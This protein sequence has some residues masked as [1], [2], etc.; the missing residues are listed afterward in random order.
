MLLTFLTQAYGADT[1][2]TV[3][4]TDILDVAENNDGALHRLYDKTYKS[5]YG[6]ALSIT[7]DPHDA[8]DT[9]QEVFVA[10]MKSSHTYSPKGKPMAWILTLTK[11]LSFSKLRKRKNDLSLEESLNQNE[12]AFADID[13]I[14]TKMIVKSLMQTLSDE[15]RQIV[16]LKVLS[17]LKSREIG[18]ILGIPLNTVLSKYSRALKKLKNQ[19]E[20]GTK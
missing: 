9:V 18:Q 19:L 14:E 4:D 3:N 8:E 2:C 7:K 6:F 17:G 5:I 12:N 11:N 16:T 13:S 15:E 1:M 20:G 10:I